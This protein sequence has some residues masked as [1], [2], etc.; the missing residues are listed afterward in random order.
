MTSPSGS[1]AGGARRSDIS[2]RGRI[3][4]GDEDVVRVGEM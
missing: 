3:G 1:G 4:D 2:A